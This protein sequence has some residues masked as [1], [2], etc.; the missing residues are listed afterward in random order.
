MAYNS[1]HEIRA[2]LDLY[3]EGETTLEQEEALRAFFCGNDVP[4]DLEYAKAMFA[5][6]SSVNGNEFCKDIVI[7][8]TAEQASSNAKGIPRRR[9]LLRVYSAVSLAAAAILVTVLT[10]TLS[11][12]KPTVYCY[13]N[14]EP[15]T[16]ISIAERQAE[17]AIRLLQGSAKASENGYSTIQEAAKPAQK[18]GRAMDIIS[19]MADVDSEQGSN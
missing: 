2:L 7:D 1:E 14:G 16:D 13:L 8:Y 9:T 17:M 6:F 12:E 10:I 11:P 15:V 3:F 18:L 19:A 5:G 4:A